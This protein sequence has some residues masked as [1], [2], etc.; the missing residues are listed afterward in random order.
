MTGDLHR[1]VAEHAREEEE[2]EFPKLRAAIDASQ[3]ANL[4]GEVSREKSMLL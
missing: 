2:S 1:I 4:V 3:T